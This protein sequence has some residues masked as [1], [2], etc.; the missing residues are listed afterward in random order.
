MVRSVP[1]EEFELSRICDYSE[2][3]RPVIILPN[4][5][6]DYAEEVDLEDPS[7]YLDTFDAEYVDELRADLISA[8]PS[9]F[10]EFS[11]EIRDAAK[12]RMVPFSFSER[13]YLIDVYDTPSKRVLLKCGRQVEKSTTLGN[14]G[15][16]YACMIPGFRILYVSPSNTQ[17]KTF[18]QDRLK[19]PILTSPKL[20]AWT[21]SELMDN[22]FQKQFINRSSWILRYA[23]LNADRVRGIPA[24]MIDIDEMQ[25]I[26]LENLPVIEE[27]ASHSPF[28]FFCYSGTPLSLDNPMEYWWL[29]YSTQ[30]E[31][32][33]PCDRCGSNAEGAAGRYWN[34]LD[35][36]NVGLKGLIC[37][38]CGELINPMH[39][40]ARWARMANPKIDQPYEAFRIPQL[41]VPWIEW[42]DILDKMRKYSVAQ[43]H[44]EVLG[45]SYDSG[46][47]PLAQQDVID[48]CNKDLLMSPDRLLELKTRLAGVDVFFGIDWGTGENNS[49]T[50]INIAA[51][52]EDRF[53]PF[54][55][56]RFEGPE[57]EPDRQ[58]SII[59]DLVLAWN[60]RLIGVDYG[61]GFDRNDKLVRAYGSKRVV[62]Y[63]YTAP[64]QKVRW[65]DRL[66][67][68]VVHRTEVMSDVFNAIKRRNVFTFP[69]WDI[70]QEPFGQD[71][72]NI[73][74]EYNERQRMIVYDKTP[75]TTDDAFHSL[76]L[77]FLVSILVHPRPDILRPTDPVKDEPNPYPQD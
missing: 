65:E 64:S 26:L 47:R 31:W 39:P 57:T 22:V 68:F 21:T 15:M 32:V 24:D 50:V 7:D 35:G 67:R 75:G 14:K 23:F 30:C 2:S 55:W 51:Y 49:F 17:T 77:S 73:Y 29:N 56:H 70:F 33:V 37:D 62:K 12:Q 43:F 28:K 11:V 42:G 66:G 46:S 58:I 76:V 16:A 40:E 53:T 41:M 1:T 5:E 60:P 69:S 74:S 61:G 71:M 45:L 27:C 25:S 36:D 8:S 44:N 72:L 34:I 9:Q 6:P 38:N 19:E 4:G 18:S 59:K 48:N 3:D 63:Q 52:L 54:F 20:K 10:V 13:R